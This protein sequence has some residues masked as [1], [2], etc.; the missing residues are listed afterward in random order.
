MA[1]TIDKLVIAKTLFT[2]NPGYN[3]VNKVMNL[4]RRRMIRMG[5]A[6]CREC[7][8]IYMQNASGLC[9]DCY[10]IAEDDELKV[11]HYLQDHCR[12]SIREVHEAT[13]VSETTILKMIKKGRITSDAELSY[14][15][16]NCGKPIF[17]G[18]VCTDCGRK[19]RG[20]IKPA[21][22]PEVKPAPRFQSS[23][24]SGEGLHTRFT[25]K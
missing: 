2:R 22:K 15:C 16:K 4:P 6:N 21:Q 7:G 19:F 5:L 17:E 18:S 12:A 14:P 9:Q 3:V 24:L 10:R 1:T 20:L 8:K 25:K 23:K 11:A 13:R